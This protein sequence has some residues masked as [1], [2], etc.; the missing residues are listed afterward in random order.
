M[1]TTPNLAIPIP[2]ADPHNLVPQL[3]ESLLAVDNSL[4]LD[5]NVYRDTSYASL[6]AAITA[7]GSAVSTLRISTSLFPNGAN[8]TVPTT[9]TL[10]FVGAGSLNITTGQTV[11]ILS[12]GSNWPLRKI[13]YNALA[14]QGTMSFVDNHLLRVIH[15][16][17]WGTVG[18]WNGITGT[19]NGTALRAA[20][21][22]AKTIGAVT[23]ELGPGAYYSTSSLDLTSTSSMELRATTS[24][25]R[26]NSP[27][28]KQSALIFNVSGSNPLIDDDL[29]DSLTIHGIEIRYTHS[30]FTGDVI[31]HP[32]S[33]HSYGLKVNDFFIGGGGAFPSAINARSG[34]NLARM[35]GAVISDGQFYWSNFGISNFGGDYSNDNKINDVWFG[36]YNYYAIANPRIHWKGENLTFEPGASGKAQGIACGVNE[37]GVLD[38]AGAGANADKLILEN[39][40]WWDANVNGGVCIEWRGNGLTLIDSYMS[41]GTNVTHTAV[42]MRGAGNGFIFTG[43]RMDGANGSIF[44]DNDTQ[45]FRYVAMDDT[46]VLIPLSGTITRVST[47][48]YLMPSI[49]WPQRLTTAQIAILAGLY[50]GEEADHVG[51]EVWDSTLAVG[52]VWDGIAFRAK[53]SQVSRYAETLVAS[54]EMNLNI[55]TV[56]DAWT[57]NSGLNF[58]PTFARF[59]S[60]SSGVFNGGS[61]TALYIKES[62]GGT[63]LGGGVATTNANNAAHFLVA[64]T[65]NPGSNVPR[66]VANGA[67][68]QVQADLAYGSS[69]FCTVDIFGYFY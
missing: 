60:I 37:S 16:C 51:V 40:G 25:G 54:F 56:Q 24:G 26:T 17:W 9:L 69:R 28:G 57:N 35:N 50:S 39:C 52:K 31:G 33:G 11:I 32:P 59:R 47:P 8:V 63:F 41:V 36:L 29:S 46:N 5:A 23:V 67:K 7:I 3:R 2:D 20:I 58:V 1:D 13:F 66:V 22:A 4:W 18:D 15:T 61:T 65:S 14:S 44:I 42:R 21:A 6:S 27:S 38:G 34:V 64:L 53:I 10:E 48:G 62:A 68:V 45:K 55:G 12:D 30:S 49:G 43:N 19:D